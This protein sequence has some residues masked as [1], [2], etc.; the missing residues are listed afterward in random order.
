MNPFGR[1]LLLLIALVVFPAG[2]G[3]ASAQ[4][5]P[6]ATQRDV[7][8]LMRALAYDRTL[9]ERFGKAERTAREAGREL[10][11]MNA[12]ELDALWQRVK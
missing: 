6:S 1:V 11:D 4:E 7:L 10:H 12:D 9:S 3:A 5:E 8:V 2:M